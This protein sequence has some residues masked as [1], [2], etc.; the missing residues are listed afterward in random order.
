[1][2]GNVKSK[3]YWILRKYILRIVFIIK[4]LL[5]RIFVSISRTYEIKSFGWMITKRSFQKIVLTIIFLI[6][7][8][9]ADGLVYKIENIPTVENDIFIPFVIG[10]ISI[11]GVILGLYCSNIASIYSLRYADAPNNIARAF[12]EDSLTCWCISTIINYII[13]GFIVVFS[14]MASIKI[15]WIM[16]IA[17]II[18]SIVVIVSHSLTR[19]RSYQL[20]DIYRLAADSNRIIYRIISKRLNHRLFSADSSFQSYFLKIAEKQI[21]LL[22]SIQKYGEKINNN[23][24][25]DNSSMIDFMVDNLAIVELYW[26]NKKNISRS[27]CWYQNRPK[28][29][30]W[31]LAD[32]MESSIAIKT[33]TSLPIKEEHNFSWLEDELITINKNCLKNLFEQ[34]DYFSIYKYIN[35]FKDICSTAIRCKEA[36]FYIA[37]VD[38]IKQKLEQRISASGSFDDDRKMFAGVIDVISLLY[39]ELLI[40]SNQAY[41]DFNLDMIAVN[42]IKAIDSGKD[43]EKNKYICGRENI[44][45]YKKIITEVKVEGKRITPDWIIKQQLAKEEYIYLNSLLD[46]VQEAMDHAFSLGKIL[47]EKKLYLEACIILIRFYE[48]E[49]KFARFKE[50]VNQKKE[51]LF[52]FQ[53]EK[54]PKWDT[55]RLNNLQEK[56]NELKKAVP[57]LLITC[58]GSFALTTWENSDEY[59]DFLG[60]C[61]NHICEDA[62]EA[63]TSG[64]IV[65]FKIDFESLS[66][67]MILYQEY[68]K[69]DFAKNIGLYRIEYAYYMVTSP[70]V[71][72]T[73]IGGLAILWGEF[74]SDQNWKKGVFESSDWIFN[75]EGKFNVF[76]EKI[77][78]YVQQRDKFLMGNVFMRDIVET[79]WK[80]RVEDSIRESGICE[81][82]YQ[83]YGSRLKTN[84]KL[85]KA[86]C[87]DF[88]DSGFRIDPSEV[89]L[90]T[91]V[92]PNIP[93]EKRFHSNYSWE[94]K[95]ND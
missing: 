39:L 5:Y 53:I 16:V 86:F 44:D 49:S 17:F 11:A 25:K 26:E 7:L 54:S 67:F 82:E 15:G 51:E 95:L 77:V 19:N 70:I 90:V 66:K 48:F 65:Q 58:S 91:C 28:Y 30:R 72:W 69:K 14:A 62:V 80:E 92:N 57:E 78:E 74:H 27:S 63:I 12:Q 21:N 9:W 89:F 42:V 83:I 56:I 6:F 47:S 76:A 50:I 22:K 8:S 75:K 45:F 24:N 79:G 4:K 71:E 35:A 23:E 20:S 55:F 61:Y 3:Y 52:G 73:Q 13:F 81:A 10:G 59:P 33:G 84:S 40:E 87:P 68:I 85:L 1:M 93:D 2:G 94:D 88:F 43:A 29:Q 41:K 60:D 18:Y 37:H 36:N 64:N 34:N 32:S 38:W 46:I 31:H